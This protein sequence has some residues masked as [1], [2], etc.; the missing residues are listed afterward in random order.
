MN[1]MPVE[2]ELMAIHIGL[3]PV[4]DN[5]NI[6][7][8]LVIT[9]AISAAKYILESRPNPLQKAVLPI[10]SKLKSFLKKDNRNHVHFW[11]CPKKAKWPRHILVDDQVKASAN[12]PTLPN[13]NSYL[14][15]RKKECDGAFTKWQKAFSTEKRK[16]QLFLDFEDNKQ[17][18]IKPT[19]TKG[20]SY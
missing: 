14:F 11:Q 20:R 9:D 8:I 4:L 17:R 7:Q 19:Y 18:V 3:M 13:K 16:G 2:A 12:I 15:S 10:V 5:D 6:H 1:I